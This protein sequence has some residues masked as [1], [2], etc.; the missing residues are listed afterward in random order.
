LNSNKYGN[1]PITAHGK[2]FASFGEIAQG[3]LSNGDDF[4]LTL[5]VDLWSECK[6]TCTHQTEIGTPQVTAP[7][8]QAK[9]IATILLKRLDTPQNL[10]LHLEFK[11]NIPIGK[12]LS[13]S[14]ADMLAVVRAFESAFDLRLTQEEISALFTH[15]EPHDPLHYSC[16]VAYNHRQGRLLKSLDYI[17]QFHIIGIDSGGELSTEDYNKH[18][19]YS[20]NEIRKYDLLYHSLLKAFARKDD[21]AI[22][23]CAQSSAALHASRTNNSFL[24]QLLDI[25]KQLDT[26]GLIATHSGTCAGL[27]LSPD[28]PTELQR[29]ISHSVAHLGRVFETETL[30][31]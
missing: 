31:L 22:A 14:T 9:Y 11:R 18:L 16:S 21:G 2:S 25:S 12:G 19:H 1:L 23:Q 30:A 5:P 28:S 29:Y 24:S 26:L 20:P 7:L 6:L 13:S 15:I 3:R 10:S 17:P 4:L 27:L 8:P